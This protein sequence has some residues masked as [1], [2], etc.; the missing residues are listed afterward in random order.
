MGRT[1][2]RMELCHHLSVRENVGLGIEAGL[3]GSRPWSHIA[4]TRAEVKRVR[5]AVDGA[6]ARCSLTALAESIVGDLSTGQC[7][8][9]ELARVVAGNFSLLLL[10]EPSSGLD[11]AETVAFGVILKELAADAGTGILLVEHDMSLVLT[12][13]DYV[14]VL[15]FGELIFE[16]TPAEI[17]ASPMVQKAY[18]GSTDLEVS[19]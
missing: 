16:G 14:Y 11:R 15:D 3:A 18:L 13:C 7:R 19:A 6:L 2:Q 9:V 17:V 8:L 1:F 12:I 5:H 4:S 10:D